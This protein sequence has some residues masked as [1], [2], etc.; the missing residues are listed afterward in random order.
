M[1][2]VLTRSGRPP[3]PE[4]PRLILSYGTRSPDNMVRPSQD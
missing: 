2:G 1:H 3:W 4:A